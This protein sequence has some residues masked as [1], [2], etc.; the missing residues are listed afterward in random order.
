VTDLWLAIIAVAVALMAAIQVG[1][2]VIGLRLAKR[3]DRLTTDIERDVKPML[4]NLTE[5]TAEAQR[6]V[7]LASMQVERADRII[8]D[9]AVSAERTLSVVTQFVGGPARS[10]M[11]M[12]VDTMLQFS[13][14]HGIAPTTETFPMTR[15]NDAL[16]HLRSGKARYRIVLTNDLPA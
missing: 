14:R 16:E 2:I 12:S 10:G 7:R 11:A 4:Q 6:A 8:G 13:A 5:M 9:V 15:A 1:A 3:V